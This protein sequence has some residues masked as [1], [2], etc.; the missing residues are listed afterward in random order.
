M[1]VLLAAAALTYGLVRVA[2]AEPAHKQARKI[3][4]LERLCA[5]P[6]SKLTLSQADDGAAIARQ[7]GRSDLART[8][9][10]DGRKIRQK[11][12]LPN[13]R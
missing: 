2:V 3:A 12:R 4:K 1:W 9:E 6:S 10:R 11:A 13:V 5:V 7:L 8:F